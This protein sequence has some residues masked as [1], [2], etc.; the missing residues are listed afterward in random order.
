MKFNVSMIIVPVPTIGASDCVTLQITLISELIYK[1]D[2]HLF[3]VFISREY[4]N[5]FKKNSDSCKGHLNDICSWTVIR[6]CCRGIA[7]IVV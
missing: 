3:G 2:F 1:R 7:S 5:R 6:R 4:F